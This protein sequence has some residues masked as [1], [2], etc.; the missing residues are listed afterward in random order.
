MK[1][2]RRYKAEA[3]MFVFESL[4]YAQKELH[5]GKDEPSEPLPEKLF[6]HD[7]THELREAWKKQDESVQKSHISGQD[8]CC[9]A[10][11]YAQKRYGLLAKM[12]LESIGINNTGDIGNIVYNLISIG[13]MRKTSQD[14]REDFDDV[15]EFETAFKK[16]LRDKT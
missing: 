1:Q 3:Y 8:L 5:L 6:E 9:A 14:R 10:R 15:F 12:V 7:S 4:D 2:D 13:H 16:S 11:D